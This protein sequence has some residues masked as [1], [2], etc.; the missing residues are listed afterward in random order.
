MVSKYFIFPATDTLTRIAIA[1]DLE[2]NRQVYNDT[3]II[4]GMKLQW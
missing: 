4:K 1:Y 3:Y 2:R